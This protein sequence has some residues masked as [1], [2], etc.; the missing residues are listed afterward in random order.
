MGVKTVLADWEYIALNNRDVHI[1]FDSDV[2]TKREVHVALGRLQS[3]L[4]QRRANVSF[5]Y[6]PPGE[7]GEKVGLDD[8]FAA[9]N[10]VQA[11]MALLAPELRHI[12]DPAE[13]TRGPYVVERGCMCHRK[14]DRDGEVTPEAEGADPMGARVASGKSGVGHAV[15]TTS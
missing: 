1:V 8:F 15:D 6:L 12:D 5:V 7:G 13:K 3:L 14:S 10:N 2:M 9:G 11:L 4:K